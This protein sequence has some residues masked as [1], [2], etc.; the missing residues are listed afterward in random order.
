MD[1]LGEGGDLCSSLREHQREALLLQLAEPL[2]FLHTL[3]L[4]HIFE[5]YY[6]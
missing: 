4:M 5:Y 3:D 6:R 1:P 2:Q